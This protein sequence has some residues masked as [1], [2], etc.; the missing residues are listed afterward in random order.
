MFQ[1]TK[2]FLH[3]V[4]HCIFHLFIF[5]CLNFVKF[6]VEENAIKI[7]NYSSV[8]F[9]CGFCL[10]CPWQLK[11]ICQSA[12]KLKKAFTYVCLILGQYV[13]RI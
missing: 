13:L 3:T 11:D 5:M 9:V 7:W 2:C 8:S 6:Q 12:A 10:Y 4:F 1:S